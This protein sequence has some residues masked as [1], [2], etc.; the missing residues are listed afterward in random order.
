MRVFYRVPKCA[1]RSVVTVYEVTRVVFCCEEMKQQW[2]R[3]IGFGVKD[4]LRS[5]S[6][7][8]SL[9]TAIP[10][11]NGN[12]L[13]EVTPVACCPWCGEAVETCREK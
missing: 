8:V 7:D 11:V 2:G 5:T 1:C 6:R 3:L 13:L 12:F 4:C 10:Q 9:F